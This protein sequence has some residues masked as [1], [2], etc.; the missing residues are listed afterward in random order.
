MPT[1]DDVNVDGLHGEQC[2]RE[3]LLRIWGQSR[4]SITEW[5]DAIQT[6]DAII[7]EAGRHPRWHAPDP[8]VVKAFALSRTGRH[9]EG[10]TLL[11]SVLEGDEPHGVL[12]PHQGLVDCLAAV[13]TKT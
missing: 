8:L 13:A 6:I 11:D 9:A 5:L 4:S 12:A 3:D 1:H 2:L 7:E 10:R